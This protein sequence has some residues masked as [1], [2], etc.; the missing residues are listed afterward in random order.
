MLVLSRKPG[1]QVVIGG[2]IT[3]TVLSIDGC[4]VKLGFEAPGPVRILRAELVGLSPDEPEAEPD[5]DHSGKPQEW[6]DP[7]LPVQSCPA[8]EL[9]A[10]GRRA[11][12]WQ[13]RGRP[14][15]GGKGRRGGRPTHP[16]DPGG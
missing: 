12:N 11:A 4:N 15:A 14:R 9:T 10:D 5:P 2:N 8:R 1:E 6:L 16:A 3:V 7:G 13:V